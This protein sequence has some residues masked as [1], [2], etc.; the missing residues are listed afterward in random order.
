MA[1]LSLEECKRLARARREK[2]MTQ[3]ALAE[4]VG[5]RQSAISMLE[6]GQSEKLSLEN[7]RKAAAVLGVELAP[8]GE[9]GQEAASPASRP[10]APSPAVAGFC[11]DA[12]CPSN[13]PYAVGGELFFWP[14]RQPAPAGGRRRCAFCGELLETRCPSCGAPLSDGACCAACG[15]PRV[16]NILPPGTD[17]E[18]WA[19]RRRQ[20]L[21]ELRRLMR[22]DGA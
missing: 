4:A 8:A 1:R 12:R 21:A 11:P 6:A 16:T 13:I 15:A 2:G 14:L 20:E 22:G 18:A 19:A 7:V 17:A 3:S 10:P 5:C 9:E